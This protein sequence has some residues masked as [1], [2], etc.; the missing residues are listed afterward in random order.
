MGFSAAIVDVDGAALNVI[1]VFNVDVVGDVQCIGCVDL[2][3]LEVGVL[4]AGN[5]SF[6]DSIAE[7]GVET[8]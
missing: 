4:A 3:V 8:V 2:I 1:T 7:L 5:V 6:D